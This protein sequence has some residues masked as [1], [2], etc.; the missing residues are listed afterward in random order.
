[1]HFVAAPA[2]GLN[3][4]VVDIGNILHDTLGQRK[5]ERKVFEMQRRHHHHGVRNA[6]VDERCGH[7]VDDEVGLAR[8]VQI[9]DAYGLR[10][11]R[12]V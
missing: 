5:A 2:A 9:K 3:L 7:L 10:S 6:V 11:S 12:H 1:M 8:A 4:D